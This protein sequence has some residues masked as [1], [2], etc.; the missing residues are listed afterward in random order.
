MTILFF[1]KPKA[2]TS[3]TV[4]STG[5]GGNWPQPKRKNERKFRKKLEDKL[6]GIEELVLET[7]GP[8]LK[9]KSAR[10]KFS[11]KLRKKMEEENILLMLFMDDE[12]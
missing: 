8:S 4:I 1:L 2:T 3:T 7:T 6:K 5:W 9:T 10:D 12:D 11:K